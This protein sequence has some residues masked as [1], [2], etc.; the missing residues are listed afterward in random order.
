MTR[1]DGAWLRI[2]A[3]VAAV[4][5]GG[6]AAWALLGDDLAVVRDAVVDAGPWG[7]AVFVALHVVLSL[8]PVPRSLLAVV[9][10]ALFGVG[11]GIALSVLASVLSAAV[12]FAIGRRLGREAVARLTGPR[13]TRVDRLLRDRGLLAVLAARLTPVAPFVVTNYG[14]G[15]SGVRA[16]DYTLGTVIGV[17]PGSVAWATVGGTADREPG[18]LL[19]AVTVVVVLLVAAGFAGRRLHGHRD[20]RPRVSGR[21]RPDPNGPA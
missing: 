21:P 1:S 12:T 16:R 14:S 5:A 11:A 19:W 20:R 8:V 13:A 2:A 6:V 17:V 7:G 9:A 10:G 4:S 18:A 15:M 3:L